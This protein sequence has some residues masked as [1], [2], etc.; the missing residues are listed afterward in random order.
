MCNNAVSILIPVYDVQTYIAK[1]LE[2]VASQTYGGQMEC[3][4]VDDCGYDDSIAIAEEFIAGYDGPISFRIIH[5]KNNRGLAAARNTGVAAA[6]GDFVFHLDGDDWIEPTAIELLIKKQQDTDADIVSGNFIR[7]CNEGDILHLIPDFA[8]PMDMVYNAIELKGVHCV[9]M[10]LIRKSL[11][12]DNDISAIEGVD[13][14]EDYHTLPRLTY[15][16]KR[17]A[18]IDDVIYH[19]NRLNPNSYTSTAAQGFSMKRFRNIASS[20]CIL[21]DFFA[22]K[23]T[24]CVKQLS[25]S[26]LYHIYWSLYLCCGLKDKTS[27][28]LIKQ[29]YAI[30]LSYNLTLLIVLLYRKIK[31]I[32][33]AILHNVVTNL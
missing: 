5:H 10:R 4:I 32:L 18:R 28:Q 3:I 11:Y 16:A 7:H 21:Q 33:K 29:E 17:I 1:C 9:C 25:A 31:A 12:T 23:D 24:H 22:D 30:S 26:R 14:S 20:I 27:F 19:Y 6:Q 2:S 15:Y 8:T 13:I